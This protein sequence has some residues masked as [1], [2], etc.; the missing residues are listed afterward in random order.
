MKFKETKSVDVVK[1]IINAIVY[2]IGTGELKSGDK[3]P[4]ERNL[5]LQMKVGRS[6]LR[7]ALKALEL[8]GLIE[9]IQGRGIFIKKIT[10]DS[11]LNPVGVIVNLSNGDLIELLKVRKVLEVEAIRGAIP[12]MTE[13]DVN[14]LEEINKRML[15]FLKG[16][17][18]E[19]FI[20][21]DF[22][23]HKKIVDCS[24]NKV[25]VN[26]IQAIYPMI[27]QSIRATS[28]AFGEDFV[29]MD[30]HTQIINKI[31]EKD[32]ESAST[33]ILED[34]NKIEDRLHDYLNLD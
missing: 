32:I 4:S 26:L 21:E 23:Y 30:C 12:N 13:K 18:V 15:L 16:K 5:A 31:K 7:E 6:S 24:G 20:K 10:F 19:K 25:L 8:V 29:T 22:K 2:K 9:K 28:K 3:L 1:E 17:Q 11:I 33:I 27:A 14:F 34:L